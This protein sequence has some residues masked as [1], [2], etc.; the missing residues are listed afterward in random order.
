MNQNR[1]KPFDCVQ[2]MR[3]IRDRISHEIGGLTAEEQLAWLRTAKLSDPLLRRPRKKA[4][5]H[6]E[7]AGALRPASVRLKV[8]S[9]RKEC[10]PRRG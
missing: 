6:R 5:Q 10:A 7:V 3:D 8:P 4:A 9:A 2:M 1:R